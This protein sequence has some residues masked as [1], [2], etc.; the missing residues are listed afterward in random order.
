MPFQCGASAPIIGVMA[1]ALHSDEGDCNCTAMRKASRWLSQMYDAALAPAGL[2]ST[3]YSILREL[4]RRVDDPP[5]MGQL[6]EVMVMD[7]ST[8]GHNLIPL[9]RDGL[10][11]LEPSRADR[12]SKQVVL[13]AEGRR[14][15][16]EALPL[17]REAQD[18]FEKR[19][20]EVEAAY[21]RKML[22]GIAGDAQLMQSAPASHA[23][24]P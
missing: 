4:R 24:A 3:Q 2:R 22:L 5:L 1:N 20:G 12:R 8:L 7:R 13:T 21:L 16:A 14:K 11:R 6:A 10:V 19:F 9:E 17:W 15:Y 18:R 23:E